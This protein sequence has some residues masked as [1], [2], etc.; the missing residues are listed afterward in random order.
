MNNLIISLLNIFELL[1][2]AKIIKIG[3]YG[4]LNRNFYHLLKNKA[5]ELIMRKM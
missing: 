1:K 4:I 5:L 3:C 2:S